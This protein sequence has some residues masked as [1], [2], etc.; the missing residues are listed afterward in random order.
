RPAAAPA[1]GAEPRRAGPVASGSDLHQ[2]V[3]FALEHPVDLRD[4]LIGELLELLLGPLALILGDLAVLDVLVDL[5][6]GVATDV[7]H[8]D[9]SV[10]GAIAHR[11]RELLAT[12]LGE[13]RKA[14]PDDLSVVRRIETEVARLDRLLDRGHRVTVERVDHEQAR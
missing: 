10:L 5:F 6:L 7:A 9:A 11:L 12:L 13:R 4:E 8:G 3:L 1:P 14:E 2:L